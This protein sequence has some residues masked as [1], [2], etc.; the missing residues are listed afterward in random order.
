[1]TSQDI[2]TMK[3]NVEAEILSQI[4][5]NQQVMQSSKTSWDLKVI[6]IILFFSHN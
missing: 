2:E 3:K 1:M 4:Q 6:E 5:T